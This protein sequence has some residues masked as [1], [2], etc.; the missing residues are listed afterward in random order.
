MK[1]WSYLMQ[2]W[3]SL[4]LHYG[5]STE[6]GFKTESYHKDRAEEVLRNWGYGRNSIYLSRTEFCTLSWFLLR[7]IFLPSLNPFP[8]G[9][10]CLFIPFFI[11]Q[12]FFDLMWAR[13]VSPPL[14]PR[15]CQHPLLPCFQMGKLVDVD[16]GHTS[17][18]N[19]SPVCNVRNGT[20]AAD[21]VPG[22]WLGQMLVK[23]AV[24]PPCF[25]L[26]PIDAIFDLLGGISEEMVCLSLHGSDACV[27]EE[28]PVVDLVRLTR[29]LGVADEVIFIVLLNEILHDRAGLEEPNCLTIFEGVRQSRDST[30]GVDFEKPRLFLDVLSDVNMVRLIGK[31]ENKLACIGCGSSS[32][33]RT[34]A[35][36]KWWISWYHLGSARYK[37]W[38]REQPY[39]ISFSDV[40]DLLIPV[41]GPVLIHVSYT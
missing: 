22:C 40:I 41:A 5:P 19:P 36:L 28:E 7:I 8:I 30:V 6:K 15:P 16:S 37:G 10:C 14:Y 17:P 12:H 24:Q 3:C 20:L 38:F 2:L 27:E 31:T 11:F 25:I 29:A 18:G 26:V 35:P 23:D 4:V 9:F 32:G 34:W 21:E 1:L 13:H 39:C 33:R